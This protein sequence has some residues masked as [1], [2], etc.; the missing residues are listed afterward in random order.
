[1]P[2]C[3][4]RGPHLMDVPRVLRSLGSRQFA[5]STVESDPFQPPNPRT[6]NLRYHHGVLIQWSSRSWIQRFRFFSSPLRTSRLRELEYP[7]LALSSCETSRCEIPNS[8]LFGTASILTALQLCK[9]QRLSAGRH[10]YL[11]VSPPSIQLLS[12]LLLR[13]N[14]LG[15][16]CDPTTHDNSTL[17]HEVSLPFVFSPFLNMRFSSFSLEDFLSIKGLDLCF[18]SA[19][20]AAKALCTK[21]HYP[22]RASLL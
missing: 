3:Q 9:I 2:T 5:T 18:S 22:S 14:S 17:L 4:S 7:T 10:F 19:T 11:E 16:Q 8:G 12:W 20:F 13:L 15:T 21:W 1:V 6:P